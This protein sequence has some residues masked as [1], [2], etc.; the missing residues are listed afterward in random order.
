[1]QL[2][3]G[4]VEQNVVGWFVSSPTR[5]G[6]GDGIPVGSPNERSDVGLNVVP[7]TNERSNVGL[8]VARVV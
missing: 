6:A 3:F 5:E 8:S 4:R 7:S 1:M 2:F